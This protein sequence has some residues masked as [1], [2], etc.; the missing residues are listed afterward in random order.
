[1]SRPSTHPEPVPRTPGSAEDEDRLLGLLADRLADARPILVVSPPRGASTAFAR[2]LCQHSSVERYFHEPCGRF[3]YEHTSLSN[4]LDELDGLTTGALIKE[5]TFQFREPSVADCFLRH[6][7]APGIFLVRSPLLTVESRIRMV[8]IDL[9]E[10]PSTAEQARNL[11]RE[12]I[13]AKDYSRVG[14]LLT[15]AVFPLY[16]TGWDDLESQLE[17]CRARDLD[18]VIVETSAFRRKPEAKLKRLCPLLGLEYESTML[19]WAARSALPPG[20][21]GRHA[22]WYARVGTSTGVLPPTE[23]PLGLERFPERFRAHLPAALR[24]YERAIADPRCL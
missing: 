13:D 21:L 12:A 18:H 22:N 8:L 10:D 3:S 9:V 11:A 5:M 14:D 23:E 2:A 16:R 15:D 1:M 7:R 19:Q 20:A 6:C 4:V 24:T 17:L